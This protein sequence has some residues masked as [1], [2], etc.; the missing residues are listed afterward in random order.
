MVQARSERTCIP[1]PREVEVERENSSVASYQ[2]RKMGRLAA[3]RG[4][5]IDYNRAGC[6]R[7]H[8]HNHLRRL[9]L[10]SKNPLAVGVGFENGRAL[11]VIT[12]ALLG[13]FH[14]GDAPRR[15]QPHTFEYGRFGK[16][17]MRRTFKPLSPKARG[18]LVG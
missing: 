14:A 18:Q 7:E 12:L 4:R 8:P 17:A 5:A 1:E 13:T 15:I 3:G 9:R 10:R 6:G 11:F 16:A 2:F